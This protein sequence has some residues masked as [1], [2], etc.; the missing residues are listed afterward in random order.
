MV[1]L[2]TQRLDQL[3][4]DECK[5]FMKKYYVLPSS[6]RIRGMPLYMMGW[7]HV[8]KRQDFLINKAPTWLMEGY[9]LFGFLGIVP[10]MLYLNNAGDW[11]LTP[12]NYRSK[13]YHKSGDSPLGKWAKG[14]EIVRCCK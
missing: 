14:F 3:T 9:D 5:V 8:L 10:L 4:P 11:V 13:D 2:L 12:C 6:I 1:E 7:N